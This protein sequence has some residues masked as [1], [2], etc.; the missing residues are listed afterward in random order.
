MDNV[1]SN[2]RSDEQ[3]E[4]ILCETS[5]W[6]VNGRQGQVLCFAASLRAQLAGSLI[7]GQLKERSRN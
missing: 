3:L 1:Q 7:F 6:A 4:T 2:R 5:H